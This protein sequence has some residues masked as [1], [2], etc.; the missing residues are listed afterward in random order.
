MRCRDGKFYT[1]FWWENLKERDHLREPGVDGR[2][3]LRWTLRKW[4]V[5][6]MDGIELTQDRDRRWALVNAVMNIQVPSNAGNF[7]TS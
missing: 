4:D 6:G 5:R 7:L 2:I 1:G 3:I